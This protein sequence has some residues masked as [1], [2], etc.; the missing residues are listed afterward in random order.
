VLRYVL[1]G[2]QAQA[3]HAHRPAVRDLLESER[4]RLLAVIGRC[5]R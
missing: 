4:A 1:A 2:L 3:H 5:H